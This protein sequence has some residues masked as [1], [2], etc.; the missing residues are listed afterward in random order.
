MLNKTVYRLVLLFGVQIIFSMNKYPCSF[1]ESE[2]R[3]ILFSFFKENI[4]F[5]EPA[6]ANNKTQN[7]TKQN[8]KSNKCKVS[9]G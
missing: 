1:M 4:Y 2:N 9:K 3:P 5:L 7:N 6:N 8:K